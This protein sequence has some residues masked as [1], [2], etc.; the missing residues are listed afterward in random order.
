MALF[1]R[2]CSWMS[3][4]AAATASRLGPLTAR[5]LTCSAKKGKKEVLAGL[6]THGSNHDA[7]WFE[8]GNKHVFLCDYVFLNCSAQHSTTR[9]HPNSTQVR[10]EVNVSPGLAATASC[11][12]AAYASTTAAGSTRAGVPVSSRAE[13]PP[14]C[15]ARQ[16]SDGGQG[17]GYGQRHRPCAI[18][19]PHSR[20]LPTLSACLAACSASVLL[21][22]PLLLPHTPCPAL[23]R[24]AGSHSTHLPLCLHVT[25]VFFLCAKA[26]SLQLHPTAKQVGVARIAAWQQ[27]GLGQLQGGS[28]GYAAPQHEERT[29]LLLLPRP[30]HA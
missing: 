10:T 30:V 25:Q 28:T 15:T 14:S 29:G 12:A 5:G 20:A 9:S 2:K 23:L 22:T 11:T 16:V 18:R 21:L 27:R 24:T 19:I 6:S 8:L 17:T 26:D 1:P 4:K 7:N 13:A 3:G